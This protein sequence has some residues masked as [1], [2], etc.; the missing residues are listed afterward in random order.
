[1][2]QRTRVV[3]VDMVQIM[4]RL[5]D[6]STVLRGAVAGSQTSDERESRRADSLSESMRG[7]ARSPSPSVLS[8]DRP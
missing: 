7:L 3:Y 8:G 4:E 6:A 5:C 2:R 1:M